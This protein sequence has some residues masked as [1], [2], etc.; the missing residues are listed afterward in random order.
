M[1]SP[2]ALHASPLRQA[3]GGLWR[4]GGAPADTSTR[5][6]PANCGDRPDGADG[7]LWRPDHRGRRIRAD[8]RGRVAALVVPSAARA[9]ARCARPGSRP[10]AG[11]RLRHRRPPR[12]RPTT[13]AGHRSGRPGVGPHGVAARSRQIAGPDR[14]RERQRRTVRRRRVRRHHRRRRAVSR[15]GGAVE[16]ARRTAQDAAAERAADRQYAGLFLA[17]VGARPARPQRTPHVRRR[18][19]RNARRRGLRARAGDILEYPAAAADDR[20]AENR[21]AAPQFGIGCRPTFAMAGRNA[22]CRHQ[23][24]ASHAVRPAGRRVRARGRHA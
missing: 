9:A 13:A 8:G 3:Q 11:C 5:T 14:T 6:R 19:S 21:G 16:R 23:R 22:V 17:D 24:R 7:P 12:V 15:R 20:A 10:R 18:S 1:D 2:S 4:H